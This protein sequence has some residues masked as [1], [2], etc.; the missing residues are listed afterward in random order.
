MKTF[1]TLYYE[2]DLDK[3]RFVVV[4]IKTKEKIEDTL[5]NEYNQLKQ[6]IS[7]AQKDKQLSKEKYFMDLMIFI[8]PKLK[9]IYSQFQLLCQVLEIELYDIATF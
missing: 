2:Q 4:K 8:K 1:E 3:Y 7:K 5:R 9:K 6:T